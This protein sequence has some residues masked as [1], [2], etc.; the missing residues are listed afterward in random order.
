MS[1]I[2]KLETGRSGPELINGFVDE[3]RIVNKG[4]GSLWRVRVGGTSMTTVSMIV[5]AKTARRAVQWAIAFVRC[6][7]L[8]SKKTRRDNRDTR[9]LWIA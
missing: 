8:N 9:K 5:R 1:S 2:W 7:W 6:S 4:S 3:D